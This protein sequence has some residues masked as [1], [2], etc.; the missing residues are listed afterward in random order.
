MFPSDMLK[1]WLQE[2][3]GQHAVLLLV[4]LSTIN[5]FIF[6]FVKCSANDEELFSSPPMGAR[7]HGLPMMTDWN[8]LSAIG[9]ALAYRSSLQWRAIF[10]GSGCHLMRHALV[11]VTEYCFIGG[12]WAMWWRRSTERVRTVSLFMFHLGAGDGLFVVGVVFVFGLC[13]V[14]LAVCLRLLGFCVSLVHHILLHT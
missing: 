4:Q 14:G 7:T 6:H 13:F 11:C 1:Q 2:L 3:L 12:Y 10:S 5:F 8:S 9:G